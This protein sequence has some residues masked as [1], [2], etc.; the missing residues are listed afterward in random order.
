[1]AEPVDLADWEGEAQQEAQAEVPEEHADWRGSLLAQPVWA[2][3][4][5]FTELV[6]WPERAVLGMVPETGGQF[7]SLVKTDMPA[8][9]ELMEPME[10][11]DQKAQMVPRAA[12]AQTAPTVWTD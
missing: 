9:R 3:Q 6:A 11:M 10:R 4:T 12:M 8:E 1:M 7:A 2:A 5:E